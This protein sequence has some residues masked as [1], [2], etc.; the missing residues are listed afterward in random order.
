MS[1]SERGR[2]G[3]TEISVGGCG[4][5]R[6]I[7]IVICQGFGRGC[8]GRW[9]L[10]EG[11]LV[12]DERRRVFLARDYSGKEA[13][14]DPWDCLDEAG[15]FGVV[16]QGTTNFSDA[17]DQRVV[18]DIRVLPNRFGEFILSNENARMLDKVQQNLKGLITKLM[19]YIMAD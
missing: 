7:R 3:R 13:I 8:V 17:L 14:A 9:G 4:E 18:G 2:F 10:G 1:K 16:F 12:L 11:T 19:V 15:I 5:D 6:Q